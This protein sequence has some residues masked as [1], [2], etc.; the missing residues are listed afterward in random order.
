MGDPVESLTPEPAMPEDGIGERIRKMRETL[1]LSQ[2]QFHQRTKEADPE[3]KGVSRTVLIGYESGKFKPG[4]R[5]LRVLCST[6]GVTPA[7]L[8]LGVSKDFEQDLDEA[9]ALIFAGIGEAG[10]VQV[11]QLAL[12]LVCLKTHE[13]GALA[14]LI[15]GIASSRRGAPSNDA[16]THLAGWMAQDAE[17]RLTELTGEA[18]LELAVRQAKGNRKIE[19]LARAY[20]EAER[21]R[22]RLQNARK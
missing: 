16:I 6:F 12:A 21:A 18:S 5:E 2:S 19:A 4:A 14:T 13:Q 10:L 7:W 9:K 8:L 20:E 11:F 3:G 1:K 17:E 15:H 22:Q